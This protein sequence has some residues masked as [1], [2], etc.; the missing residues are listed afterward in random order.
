[1]LK[2]KRKMYGHHP[3]YEPERGGEGEVAF[4]RLDYPEFKGIRTKH[5]DMSSGPK[6]HKPEKGGEGD[7]DRSEEKDSEEPNETGEIQE[8]GVD[9]SED[10]NRMLVS[11]ENPEENVGRDDARSAA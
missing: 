4:N 10:Y 2:T 1:M 8:P 5:D 7:G 3:E 11:E 6:E 9:Y